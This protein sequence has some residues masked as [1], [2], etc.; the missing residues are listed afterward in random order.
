M[1]LSNQVYD[2]LKFD[3]PAGG[4]WTQGWEIEYNEK[5]WSEENKLRV[6]VVPHSHNDP[7]WIKV[8]K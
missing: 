2:K 7:G 1:F 5:Q 4:S 3:N 6:F 8:N